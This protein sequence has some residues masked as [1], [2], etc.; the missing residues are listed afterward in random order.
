MLSMSS[1]A[2]GSNASAEHEADLARYLRALWGG[3]FALRFAEQPLARSAFDGREQLLP[4]PGAGAPEQLLAR[5]R[6]AHAAAHAEF[7]GAPL[8]PGSLRP[9]QRVLVSLFEDARVE[10]LALER[11]PGLRKLWA[12]F[13][14]A[15]PSRGATL[16]ALL[17]RLS[18][19][20]F[21]PTYV[22]PDAWVNKARRLFARVAPACSYSVCRELGSVL[23]N[24]LGQMR[25]AFVAR[26]YLVEPAYRDDHSGLW[27]EAPSPAKLVA[28]PAESRA[29]D[30]PETRRGAQHSYPEWDYEIARLRPN[31]C[32]L[33]ELTPAP[34]AQPAGAP[35]VPARSRQVL[36]RRVRRSLVSA[37]AAPRYQRRCN[38]G[39]LL[40]LAALV[41]AAAQQIAEPGAP[42]RV[43]RRRKQLRKRASALVLLDLSESSNLSLASGERGSQLAGALAQLMCAAAPPE[44]ALSIYGFA[45]Y[46]RSDVRMPCFKAFDEPA[47]L[48]I[49]RLSELRGAGS[50]RLGC[51]LRHAGSLLRARGQSPKLLLVVTD[52]ECADVDVFDSAYLAQDAKHALLCARKQGIEVFG[53]CPEL[54]A[55]SAPN[56]ARLFARRGQ[57]LRSLSELPAR[58]AEACSR[59]VE[60]SR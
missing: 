28:L 48:A 14:V 50:T 8:E 31:F 41:D 32:E 21:D 6:A 34:A 13:Q 2:N 40:D 20:L 16:P 11:Y 60:G 45:S 12:P 1:V 37:L 17:A 7:S 25:L 38:D 44:L 22:D 58:L 49:A 59:W 51:A 5:A 30:N 52:G 36:I 35:Q 10:A 39:P 42:L 46:G 54:A 23:G 3:S 15:T 56:G 53:L 24:E 47:T 29:P 26:H 33:R 9:L 4:R 43:Y 57:R 18:R 19:A 27:L 55:P